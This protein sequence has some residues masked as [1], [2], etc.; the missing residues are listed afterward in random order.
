[1]SWESFWGAG[2]M[3]WNENRSLVGSQRTMQESGLIC[4]I[5]FRDK[6]VAARYGLPRPTAMR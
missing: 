1:M 4:S 2:G 6:A 5:H 3:P